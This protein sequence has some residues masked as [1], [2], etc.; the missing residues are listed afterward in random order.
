M[1]RNKVVLLIILVVIA[2]FVTPNTGIYHTIKVNLVAILPYIL[3]AVIIYLIITINVLKR[4]WKKL[5]ATINDENVINFA[6]MMN[7]TFDVK[8]M[9]GPTNL[10]DLYQKVNFSTHA[11]MHAKQLMYESLKRKRLDVPP[12][13]KGT[14]IDKI[15]NKKYASDEEMKAARIEAA[16]QAKKR[17]H[18]KQTAK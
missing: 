18:K 14:D 5:D 16:A 10:I 15:I 8:R 3:A 2:Y 6:K 1:S 11:S 7:I 12:P 13:G 9:L 17:K 4:A